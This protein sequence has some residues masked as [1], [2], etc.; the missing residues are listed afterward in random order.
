VTGGAAATMR[1]LNVGG[2]SKAIPI[3]PHYAGWEHL[4]LDIDPRGNPDVVADARELAELPAAQFDA[5]YCSHNLEH[6][7]V[8]EGRHVLRG[9][10]HVLKEDGFAEIRVPDLRAVMDRV[11]E[12]GM[13]IQDVLYTSAAG[14]ITARDVIYGWSVEIEQSG[15]DFYA[16]KT[17]FTAKS[18]LAALREAG[19]AYAVVLRYPQAFELCAFGFRRAPSPDQRAL[20][21]LPPDAR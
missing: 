15:K 2:N 17:G 13:D 20:L 9:F 3:P 21:G 8:H 14:P 1:V 10:V 7:H 4:L 12:S 6:Y 16:H 18:L 11:V 5:V 19:F